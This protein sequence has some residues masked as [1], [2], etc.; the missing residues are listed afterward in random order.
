MW[1]LKSGLVGIVAAEAHIA[2]RGGFFDVGGKWLRLFNHLP[3]V[4]LALADT[5]FT[6]SLMSKDLLVSPL[7][8]LQRP[9]GVMANF[10]CS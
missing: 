9:K 1:V 5:S 3:H 6:L 8:V 10:P 4:S 2:K 7:C